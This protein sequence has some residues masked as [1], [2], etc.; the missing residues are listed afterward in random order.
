MSIDFEESRGFT[1]RG[2]KPS[3]ANTDP[4]RLIWSNGK[5]L[6]HYGCTWGRIEELST[7]IYCRNNMWP[8]VIWI[9]H[10]EKLQWAYYD[11]NMRAFMVPMVNTHTDVPKDIEL[12]NMLLGA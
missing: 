9:W 4:V 8:E 6:K 1:V 7:H 11:I 3:L 5:M 10:L 12:F 2:G